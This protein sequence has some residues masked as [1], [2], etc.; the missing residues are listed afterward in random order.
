MLPILNPYTLDIIENPKLQ[1][2]KEKLSRYNFE[3]EWI[4]KVHCTPDALLMALTDVPG[5]NDLIGK[6]ANTHLK[7]IYRS[8]NRID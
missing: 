1:H 2:L 7:I 3:D 4:K 6:D 8:A 5:D